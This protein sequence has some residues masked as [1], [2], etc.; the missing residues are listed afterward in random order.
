MRYVGKNY[1]YPE[2]LSQISNQESTDGFKEM[3]W[4]DFRTFFIKMHRNKS[5][6]MQGLWVVMLELLDWGVKYMFQNFCGLPLSGKVAPYLSALS[7]SRS[8]NG[9]R[10]SLV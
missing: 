7:P 2:F 9:P 10:E 3:Q 1:F 5:V 6:C 8:H 4:E